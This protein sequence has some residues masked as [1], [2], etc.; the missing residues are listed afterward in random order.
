VG[1][2][3]ESMVNKRL[4]HFLELNQAF[5]PCQGG[6]CARMLAIDKVARL[7][8]AIQDTL[9]SRQVLVVVSLTLQ[10]PLTQFGIMASYLN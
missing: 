8:T 1:K 2:L 6:F 7:T 5:Q 3:F 9:N 10:V 4:T